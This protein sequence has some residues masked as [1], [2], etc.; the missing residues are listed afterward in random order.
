MDTSDNCRVASIFNEMQ[1]DYDDLRDL[2]Y[3][4][5]FARLH[6]FLAED[7]AWRLNSNNLKVLD[8]GC[9]TGFQSMLYAAIGCDVLGIDIAGDLV[10]EARKKPV[11]DLNGKKPKLHPLYYDFSR[12][13]N[14]AT[15]ALL[16]EKFHDVR[17]AIPP[18]FEVASAL[19]I[20]SEAAA[21][22]HV[23]CCGSVLSFM[24]DMQ[25]ALNEISRVLKPGGT[26]FIELE[27]RW[28]ADAFWPLIDCLLG[29]K[30]GYDSSYKE[31]FELLR[32]PFQAGVNTEYPF[33]DTRNPVYMSLRLATRRET[34]RKLRGAG[35]IADRWR[36]I[37]AF[38]NLI[39]STL[40]D[41]PNPSTSLVKV[42]SFLSS[43]EEKVPGYW[44]GCSI[45]VSG[46]K[47]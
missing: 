37:H 36:F 21:F 40:L 38:T 19:E 41:H 46:R 2:W 31:A 18:R 15:W 5:L 14:A 43:I 26:F 20:P 17:P 8:V 12:R 28:N 3:S 34:D 42:F 27:G 13:Y 25:V 22:D 4:W 47:V 24:P 29:G 16:R 6:Y 44:P 10:K 1:S 39:P 32:P 45:V 33:G 23:N 11:P 30:I 9:G 7:I 35:L